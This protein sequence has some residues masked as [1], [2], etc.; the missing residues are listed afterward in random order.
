MHPTSGGSALIH[1]SRH[2]E[3]RIMAREVGGGEAK[4]NLMPRSGIWTIVRQELTGK[5]IKKRH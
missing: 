3:I 5:N 2:R 1:K 4:K